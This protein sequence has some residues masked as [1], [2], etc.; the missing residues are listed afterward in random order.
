[1][2]ISAIRGAV[3]RLVV[4]GALL[5]AVGGAVLANG[6]KAEAQDETLVAGQTVIINSADVN[7]R[8]DATIVADVLATLNDGT[9]ATVVDGPESANNYEWYQIDVDGVTGWAVRDY[10]AY[11]AG[12]VDSLPERVTALVN[13]DSVTLRST[14]GVDA[15]VVE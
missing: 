13:T 5:A 9:W 8:S 15:E 7:L 6:G 4:A 14:A 11:A 12:S 3:S 10:L 1:M 2:G